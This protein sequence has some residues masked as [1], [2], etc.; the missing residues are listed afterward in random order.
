MKDEKLEIVVTLVSV[1]EFLKKYPRFANFVFDNGKELFN[2]IVQK[3]VFLD[4]SVL[5]NYG[6]PSVLGVADKCLEIITKSTN[7]E[8]NSFTKQFIGSVICALM[9]A[10][11]Y[12]KTGTKKSVP[13]E[14]FSTGEFYK[15]KLKISRIES[16]QLCGT[17]RLSN[18]ESVDKSIVLS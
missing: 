9:E 16:V 8:A 17:D 2:T 12:K 13:H 18:L 10:N 15:R 6:Y 3:E 1:D 4:S 14:L 5:A 11:G 7:L